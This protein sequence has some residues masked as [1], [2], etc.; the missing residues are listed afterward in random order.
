MT[1]PA[2]AGRTA[3]MYSSHPDKVAEAKALCT[4]CSLPVRCL[5]A[6]LRRGESFGVWGGLS[7]D[8]R[9]RIVAVLRTRQ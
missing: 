6:A 3:S 2:C 4:T 8:E 7:A 1:G 9:T 5:V